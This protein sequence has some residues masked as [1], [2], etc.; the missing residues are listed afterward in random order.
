M[1][2]IVVPIYNDICFLWIKI[3]K[4]IPFFNYLILHVLLFIIFP[5]N[6]TKLKILIG[7]KLLF[8]SIAFFPTATYMYI[9]FKVLITCSGTFAMENR[10]TITAEGRDA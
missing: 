7:I 4:K 8:F 10:G 3:F 6:F 1:R 5:I 9:L 2:F